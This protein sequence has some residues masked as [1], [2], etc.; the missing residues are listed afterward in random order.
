[1]DIEGAVLHICFGFDS[2][3]EEGDPAEEEKEKED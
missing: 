2:G 3:V 1:M